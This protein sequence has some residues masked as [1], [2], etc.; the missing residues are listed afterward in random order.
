MSGPAELIARLVGLC[1]QERAAAA[2][3]DM[4]AVGAAALARLELAFSLAAAD[5]A[6]LAE[7]MR[8]KAEVRRNLSLYESLKEITA[9]RQRFV[10]R[11]LK[12]FAAT[13]GPGG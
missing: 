8:L 9:R 6:P 13:Y 4:E 7:L 10:E 11:A 1:Q 2:A 12:S 5:S 3:G